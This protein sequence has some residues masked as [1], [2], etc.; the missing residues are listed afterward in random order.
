MPERRGGLVEAERGGD[1]RGHQHGGAQLVDAGK[2]TGTAASPQARIVP[3]SL[4]I[5]AGE[6]LVRAY[7]PPDGFPK[8]FCSG[9]GSALWSV[10]PHTNEIASVRMIAFDHDP[11]VRHSYRQFVTYLFAWKPI[12]DDGLPRHPEGIP[13]QPG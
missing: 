1:H 7:E 10:N 11:G 5:T 4:R 12:P 6:D 9:C 13:P 2:R 8:A 3:G